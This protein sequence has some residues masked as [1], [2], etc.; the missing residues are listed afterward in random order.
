MQIKSDINL[1]FCL[2]CYCCVHGCSCGGLCL[3]RNSTQ[4]CSTGNISKSNRLRFC[5]DEATVDDRNSRVDAA[6][7]SNLKAI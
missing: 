3:L 6:H 2:A 1:V 5:K 7:V 4:S